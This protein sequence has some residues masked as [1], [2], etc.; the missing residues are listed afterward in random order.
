MEAL[1]SEDLAAFLFK[2]MCRKIQRITLHS[3]KLIIGGS[4]SQIKL[5]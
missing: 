5:T 3:N 1:F 2:Q 4:L